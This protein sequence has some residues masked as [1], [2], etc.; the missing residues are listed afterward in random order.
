MLQI[1][2]FQAINPMTTDH[3]MIIPGVALI[4]KVQYA[5]ENNAVAIWWSNKTVIGNKENLLGIIIWS[6]LK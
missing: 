5:L 1:L 3:V 2:V 4:M 6:F